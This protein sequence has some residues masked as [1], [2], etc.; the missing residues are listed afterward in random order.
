MHHELHNL[1]DK[2]EKMAKRMGASSLVDQL[3]TSID[4]PYSVEVI[5]MPLPSK[6]LV[7]QTKMYDRCKD[8]LE[9]LETLKNHMILHKFTGEITCRAFSLTLKGAKRW[10]FRVSW[11]G[12]L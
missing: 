8:S 3:L 4:F 2:Y 12:Y 5:V 7:P 10:W 6:S 1:M 9:H 11:S